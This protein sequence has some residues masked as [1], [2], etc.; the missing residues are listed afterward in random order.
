MKSEAIIMQR[1]H[2]YKLE[3]HRLVGSNVVLVESTGEVNKI[4]CTRL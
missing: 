1:T 2:K 3:L 4:P